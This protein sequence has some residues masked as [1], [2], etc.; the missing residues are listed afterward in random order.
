MSAFGLACGSVDALLDAFTRRRGRLCGFGVR[1]V[2]VVDGKTW[3]ARVALANKV[4]SGQAMSP[5]PNR[6]ASTEILEH[7]VWLD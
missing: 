1:V 2:R 4:E 7:E 5:A 3:W 6:Q